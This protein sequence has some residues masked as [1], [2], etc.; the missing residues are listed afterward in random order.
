MMKQIRRKHAG[1]RIVE[2]FQAYMLN[3]AHGLFSS[4]GRLTRTPLPRR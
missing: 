4:L 2:L 3:H 1:N